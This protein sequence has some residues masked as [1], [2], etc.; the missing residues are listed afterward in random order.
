[1]KFVNKL[2]SKVKLPV[3]KKFDTLELVLV[4]LMVLYILI[5]LP[6]PLTL[7]EFIDTT[8]GSLVVL[9]FVVLLFVNVN[10][11]IGVLG[12][13]VGYVLLS[14]ASKSTGSDSVRKYTPSEEQKEQDMRFLN[15]EINSKSLE[16]EAVDKIPEVKVDPSLVDSTFKPVYSSDMEFTSLDEQV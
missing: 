16:E 10:P 9:L 3:L 4:I 2:L 7:A 11:A 6:L 12:L 15:S 14:R 13:L 8:V 1:M 5:P